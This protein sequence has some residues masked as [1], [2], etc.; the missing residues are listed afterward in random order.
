MLVGA[1]LPAASLGYYSVATAFSVLPRLITQSLGLIAATEVAV[2]TENE[3]RASARGFLLTAVLLII[4]IVTAV[5][6]LLPWLIPFLFG[7]AFRPALACARLLLLAAAALG[8][9]RFVTDLVRG[10]GRPGVESI[11]EIASW[12]VLVVGVVMVVGSGWLGGGIEGVASVVLAATVVSLIV[13]LA[14]LARAARPSRHSES[15]VP[16]R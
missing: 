11:A 13:A 4:V 6:V 3:R 14:Y 9:R 12:P 5:E 2:G 8:L 16:S 15:G 10:L 1:V 7:D